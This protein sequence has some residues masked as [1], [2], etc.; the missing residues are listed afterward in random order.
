MRL[1]FKIFTL[2]AIYRIIEENGLLPS[3]GDTQ[4][5]RA[6]RTPPT[7]LSNQ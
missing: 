6:T 3:E 7:P 4:A 5:S 2:W 1:I